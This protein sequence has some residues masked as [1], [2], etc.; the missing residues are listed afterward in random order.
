MWSRQFLWTG[1]A[2]GVVVAALTLAG[3]WLTIF[4]ALGDTSPTFTLANSARLAAAGLLVY[5][6]CWFFVI[7]RT[8]DYSPL[9]TLLLV[10]VTF[11]AVTAIVGAILIGLFTYGAMTMLMSA[12]PG[13]I[14]EAAS[15]LAWVPVGAV[16][17]VLIGITIMIVP[18]L[19]IATPMAF[20]HRGLLL[21]IFFSWTS[22]IN[23][24]AKRA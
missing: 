18:Y 2:S 12:Q 21:K 4:L 9:R 24:P 22:P 10:I 11:V 23:T 13:R 3:I 5:P 6:L 1:L 14:T 15:I 16:I 20:L 8:R 17:V 19:I 7:F